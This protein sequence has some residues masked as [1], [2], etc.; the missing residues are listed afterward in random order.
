M[1]EQRR[2]RLKKRYLEIIE[3]IPSISFIGFEE[4]KDDWVTL[5]HVAT[6]I[7]QI[8]M[9]SC[10]DNCVSW[11][12]GVLKSEG[13]KGEYH[14]SFR[15][16]TNPQDILPYARVS[17]DDTYL[18]AQPLWEGTFFK[19]VSI[20]KRYV[21][22]IQFDEMCLSSYCYSAYAGRKTEGD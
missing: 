2:A 11:V 17:L 4:M 19:F 10:D 21:L 7:S 3:T 14:L 9:A 12:I 20:D 13:V 15:D 6:R 5:W 22:I 18:W 1:Q 8:D 16:P